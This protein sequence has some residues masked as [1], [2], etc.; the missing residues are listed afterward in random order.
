[1]DP[2][3]IR[4]I[5]ANI[6]QQGIKAVA[7]SGIFSPID[8]SIQQEE[9]VRS[10][11]LSQLPNVRVTLSKSVANIGSCF[12]F[13][14]HIPEFLRPVG[15]GERYHSQRRFARFRF[16][17]CCRVSILYSK[18]RLRMSYLPH[19]KRRYPDDLC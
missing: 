13:Y 12:A 17:S 15:T 1:M 3:E 2:E 7:V 5:C 9:L 10:I 4:A 14:S 11:I 19:F 16:K 6:Q 18:Q 8:H